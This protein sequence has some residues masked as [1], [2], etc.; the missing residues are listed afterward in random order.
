ME[1]NEAIEFLYKSMPAFERNG[2]AD[3]KPGLERVEALD[4]A[5]GNPSRPLRAVH[6]AGTNGKG[7][8]AHALAAV[9]QAAGLRTGLFTSPHLVDFRERIRIDGQMI[10]TDTVCRFV[11]RYREMDLGIEPS[12][13]E[14]TTVMAFEAFRDAGVDV[15]VIETGLGGRLDSTNIIRPELSVITNIALDHTDLLGDTLPQIAAEKA[16]IIKP[17]VPVVV[18]NVTDEDVMRVLRSVADERKSPVT[19]ASDMAWWTGVEVAPA[20]TLTLKGTRWGDVATSLSGAFQCDNLRGV[21]AALAVL[22]KPFN[23]TARAVRDGLG[24]GIPATGLRGRWMVAG[25]NPL[26]IIDTGHNP[27]AWRR[28]VAQLAAMPGE[29]RV[30]AGFVADKDV[31]TVIDLMVEL[32]PFTLYATAPVNTH[33]ALPAERFAAMVRSALPD[34]VVQSYADVRTAVQAAREDAAPTDVLFVGGS[35]YLIGELSVDGLF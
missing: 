17:G 10:D 32:Q 5:F 28:I 22:E 19:F 18:S 13:F 34:V 26:T 35:N 20:G 29:K 6:I 25:H 9:L 3:Y 7:T 4:R 2:S 16:G 30:V 23:I 15:A 27:D 8:T 11:D 12:F 31:Q 21:L 1:Y 24:E 33:R 14:L